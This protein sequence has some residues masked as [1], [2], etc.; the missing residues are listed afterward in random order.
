MYAQFFW[1]EV[2][3]SVFEI[4]KCLKNQNWEK[5][6]EIMDDDLDT[7]FISEF[8]LK[9]GDTVYIERLQF[10]DGVSGSKV[11]DL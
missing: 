6:C 2:K 1:L 7:V 9:T 11:S 8:G 5:L 10:E 4:G 3:I